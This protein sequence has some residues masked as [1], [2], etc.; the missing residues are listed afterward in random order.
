LRSPL[1]SQSS[2]D[3][4]EQ[5]PVVHV[6]YENAEAYAAWAGKELPTEAEREK[7]VRSGRE[8]KKFT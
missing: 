8:E 5:H 7:A 1:G 3:Y 2:L 6:G 4:I